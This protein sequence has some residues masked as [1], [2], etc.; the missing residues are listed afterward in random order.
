[1]FLTSQ[2]DDEQD[3]VIEFNS[4][5]SRAVVDFIFSSKRLHSLFLTPLV[6]G[7]LS[8]ATCHLLLPSVLLENLPVSGVVF[9]SLL[10]W[11]TGCIACYSL[12]VRAPAEVAVYRAT[13]PL[14][15]RFIAKP[16]YIIGLAVAFIVIRYTKLLNFHSL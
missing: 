9:V 5:C 11:P 2:F 8:F 13:D 4:Y 10:G 1:M 12:C 3:D 14:E 7:L 16:F 15:L 6:T